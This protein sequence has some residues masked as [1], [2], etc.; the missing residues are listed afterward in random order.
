MKKLPLVL[1]VMALLA[2]M[3]LP[4]HASPDNYCTTVTVTPSGSLFN[5]TA[6]GAGRYARVRD[7]T[8]SIVVIATDFGA[9]ATTY[10]WTGLALDTAHQYQ[11]QV[12]HTSLTTGYS[13]SGCTFTPPI[14]QAVFID[15]FEFVRGAFEWDAT[16]EGV[17]YWV[18]SPAGGVWTAWT[19]AQVPGGV[20]WFQY[21]VYPVTRKVPP[22]I[23]ILM[24]QDLTG[25]S[26]E[27]ARFLYPGP[28][29]EK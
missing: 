24:A 26:D 5:V 4:A 1:L 19:P 9:G 12:S 22:G 17:G 7:L 14:P 13:T 29:P 3:T 10:T 27:V 20:G 2:A 16:W 21:R 6:T 28:K 8:N 15:R 18:T 25:Q 23:Y 11:V